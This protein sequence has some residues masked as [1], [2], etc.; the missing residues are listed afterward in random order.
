MDKRGNWG[1]EVY[2]ELMVCGITHYVIGKY[3]L[4]LGSHKIVIDS[5][6]NIF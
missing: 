4:A 2:Q 5:L 6:T 1:V 3:S